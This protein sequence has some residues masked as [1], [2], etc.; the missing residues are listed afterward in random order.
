LRQGD[1][2]ITESPTYTGAIAV[3]KSRGAEIADV[4]LSC[5]GPNL[6]ILEYNLKKYKQSLFTQ[7]RLS[8]SYRDIIFQ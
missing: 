4:P 7:Y 8:E 3:F 5:D 2:V 1:Y 6:N